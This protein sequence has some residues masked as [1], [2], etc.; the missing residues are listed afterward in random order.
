MADMDGTDMLGIVSCRV[1]Q[2]SKDHM[3]IK[4]KQHLWDRA[5][6]WRIVNAAK[7]D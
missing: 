6:V 5:G 4:N 1:P 2:G 3:I 7:Q